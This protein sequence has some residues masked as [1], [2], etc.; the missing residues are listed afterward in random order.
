MNKLL[1]TLLLVPTA[2]L[3][4][5]VVALAGPR[6]IIGSDVNGFIG[7][8]Q[9]ADKFYEQAKIIEARGYTAS[10]TDA[11]A[12]EGTITGEDNV[13]RIIKIFA[14]PF[15]DASGI[16]RSSIIGGILQPKDGI[17]IHQFITI[18]DDIG[19]PTIPGISIAHIGQDPGIEPLIHAIQTGNNPAIWSIILSGAIPSKSIQA[20]FETSGMTCSAAP[21]WFPE[22]SIWYAST[23]IRN[24]Q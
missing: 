15:T 21:I 3:L 16:H 23:C 5:S 10:W 22:K 8:I 7:N 12:G 14:I 24:T 4:S 18:A 9:L 19:H 20:A 2:F 1:S 11:I 6:I 17:Q 13:I